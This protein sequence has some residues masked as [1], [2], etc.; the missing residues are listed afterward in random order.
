MS[1]YIRGNGA[2]FSR[3]LAYFAAFNAFARANAGAI[4]VGS[5]IRAFTDQFGQY[6]SRGHG[7]CKN[8]G[9]TVAKVHRILSRGSKYQPPQGKREI[10]RRLGVAHG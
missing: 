9:F 3:A 6:K 7:R 8:T 1:K 2:P 4:G 10:A 5:L